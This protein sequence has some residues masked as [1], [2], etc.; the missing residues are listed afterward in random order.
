MVVSNYDER[1]KHSR[2]GFT[3]KIRL[4]LEAEGKKINLEASS[5]DLSLKGIF[6]STKEKFSIGTKCIVKV[7][8]TGGIDKIELQMKGTVV[9]ENDNGM[10]IEFDSMDVETY[11]HLKNIIHYNRIDDSI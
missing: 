3:A 5:K 8:L 1:R 6:A 4:L 10:G 2:V 11:S 9:R 7:Y